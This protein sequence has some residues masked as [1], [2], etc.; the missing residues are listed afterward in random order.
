MSI[1]RRKRF[2]IAA[3]LFGVLGANAIAQEESEA[4]PVQTIELQ[5]DDR[6]PDGKAAF[7]QGETDSAGRRFLVEATEVMQP[8]TVAVYTQKPE[9]DVRVQIVKGDWDKP[10]REARTGDT[11]IAEHNF[12]TFDGF[13]IRVD[14]DKPTEYQLVVWVG[15]ELAIPAP[16]IAV[17]ASEYVEPAAASGQAVAQSE[18]KPAASSGGG[19][20]LSYLELA[21]IIA[22]VA[23]A[24]ILAVVLLRRKK[25]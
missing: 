21:L 22:L 7:L 3:L 8:I 25:S 5:A 1:T 13:N 6:V 4:P 23:V 9:D 18:D 14:A 16:S 19:V 2:I 10:V 24:A 17:P 11:R 12:R 20:S 15:N